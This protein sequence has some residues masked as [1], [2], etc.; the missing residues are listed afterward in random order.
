M[1][2]HTEKKTEVVPIRMS[3]TLER[4][5]RAVAEL[6]HMDFTA[7]IRSLIEREVEAERVRYRALD[8][9][10]GHEEGKRHE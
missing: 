9:I 4:Q 10:F 5:G 2:E 3:E 6:N 8:F 7:W 1:A